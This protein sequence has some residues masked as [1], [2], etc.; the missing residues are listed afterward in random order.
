MDDS[1]SSD[2]KSV[3]ALFD[4]LPF[5]PFECSKVRMRTLLHSKTGRGAKRT[6][7]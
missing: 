1:G 2:D 7:A 3:T 6:V 5:P 4:A